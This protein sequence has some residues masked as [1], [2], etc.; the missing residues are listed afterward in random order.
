MSR[1]RIACLGLTS[2]EQN[3]VNSMFALMPDLKSKYEI[4]VADDEVR[5]AQIALVNAENVLAVR[6]W[7]RLASVN[8]ML[9]PVLLSTN[10]KVEDSVV[11]S[12]A[13][14]TVKSRPLKVKELC[15]A[16]AMACNILQ[17]QPAA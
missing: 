2:R 13:K 8:E 4:V 14:I 11:K 10:G 15:S 12:E 16:F 6:W 1:V 17:A 9:V 7:D 3:I 5:D